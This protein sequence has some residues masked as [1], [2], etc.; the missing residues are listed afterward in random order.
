MVLQK[1]CMLC[2]PVL[3]LVGD[4]P[5]VQRAAFQSTR[6]VVCLKQDLHARS[7]G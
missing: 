3:R 7:Q 5:E 2:A 4:G 1:V 6:K